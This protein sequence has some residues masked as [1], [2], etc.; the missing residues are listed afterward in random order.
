MDPIVLEVHLH[1]GGDVEAALQEEPSGAGDEA[2]DDR[3]RNEPDQVSELE[4]SDHHEDDARQHRHDQGR[5]DDG[6]E[7]PVGTAER[8][9]GGGRGDDREHR[10]HRFLQAA[11][12][13]AGARPPRQDRERERG[14]HQEQSDAV[15]QEL[16]QVA[17]VHQRGERDRQDHLDDADHDA[18]RDRRQRALGS[19]LL[20]HLPPPCEG[21]LIRGQR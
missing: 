6:D 12:H 21:D 18:G 1:A 17:A 3:V 20:D 14:R 10:H 11:H 9:Q 2:A 8:A 15:G 4:R 19:P 16:R 7:R 5:R 13:T